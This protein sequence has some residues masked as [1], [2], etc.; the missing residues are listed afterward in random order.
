MGKAKKTQELVKK[1]IDLKVSQ[2]TGL[3]K[4]KDREIYSFFCEHADFQSNLVLYG[5]VIHCIYQILLQESSSAMQELERAY[6]ESV[7]SHEKIPRNSHANQFLSPLSLEARKIYGDYLKRFVKEGL[8]DFAKP[9]KSEDFYPC[10]RGYNYLN[11]PKFY[12]TTR[13]GS[14]GSKELIL[15]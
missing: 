15:E 10:L 4:K 14:S 2:R 9:E 5:D 8:V 12:R 6:Q 3:T 1:A 13:E 11:D 7:G